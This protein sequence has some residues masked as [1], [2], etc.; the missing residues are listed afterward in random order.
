M[1]VSGGTTG[2]CRRTTSARHAARG[3]S[4]NFSPHRHPFD[5]VIALQRQREALAANPAACM[6][7]N[8]RETV[9]PLRAV[10]SSA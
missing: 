1:L 7:R 8:Y 9:T 2:V 5:Y 3:A 4:L 6:P 10:A